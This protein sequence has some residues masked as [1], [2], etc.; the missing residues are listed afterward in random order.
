MSAYEDS[1]RE[2]ALASLTRSKEAL[3]AA[4]AE[5]FSAFLASFLHAAERK[6]N[7]FSASESSPTS[8]STPTL[9]LQ[10]TIPLPSLTSTPRFPSFAFFI[11][12]AS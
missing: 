12:I 11:N 7:L 1:T 10:L 5:P 8:A 4:E 3:R 6:S 9:D 2:A